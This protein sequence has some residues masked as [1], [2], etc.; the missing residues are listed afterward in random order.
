MTQKTVVLA[1]WGSYG[2]V[3]P[4]IAVA[5]ALKARGLHPVIATTSH[6]RRKIEDEGLA[7]HPV[8][9]SSEQLERDTGLSRAGLLQTM[10]ERP[11]YLFE[12]VVL[13]YL[14]E[15]CEDLMAEF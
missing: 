13:P 2:D 5:L 6:Y 11:Q 8:R 4:F 7:F 14:V 15:A 9:P 1:T 3:H 10:V 12:T